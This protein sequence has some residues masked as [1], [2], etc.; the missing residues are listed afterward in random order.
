[1]FEWC[2]KNLIDC[3]SVKKL[4]F[5][6]KYINLGVHKLRWKRDTRLL[7]YSALLIGY[8]LYNPVNI[9]YFKLMLTCWSIDQTS[10][11]LLK[12]LSGIP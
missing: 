6:Y 7:N 2:G 8:N 3:F 9:L 11:A 5:A 10:D 1:M 12:V 4:S